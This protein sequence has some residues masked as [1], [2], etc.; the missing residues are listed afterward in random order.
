MNKTQEIFDAIKEVSVVLA[1]LKEK[2]KSNRRFVKTL[3]HFF[4]DVTD[5]REPGKVKYKLENILCICL[6]MAMRGEFTSFHNASLF[7]KV[8][9]NYF[10]KL[11]LIEGKDIPRIY[12]LTT[13]YVGF[14]CTLMPMSCVTACR[15]VLVR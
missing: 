2:L 6:L 9:V 15:F 10:K 4:S 8:K 1:P 7:I 13:P 5:F 14:L 3:L 11:K 12:R